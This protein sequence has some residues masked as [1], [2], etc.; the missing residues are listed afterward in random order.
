MARW[1]RGQEVY[2]KLM[3]NLAEAVSN[4]N[5]LFN[6][7]EDS[8]VAY[9]KTLVPE[10]VNTLRVAEVILIHE[11]LMYKTE[12]RK[13]IRVPVYEYSGGDR[14]ASV[15]RYIQKNIDLELAKQYA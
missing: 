1:K 7:S 10:F 8:A 14:I 6:I 5:D 4:H 3:S 13:D 11:Y 9:A 15:T 2:S 12:V